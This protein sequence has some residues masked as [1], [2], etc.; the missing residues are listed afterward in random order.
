MKNESKVFNLDDLSSYVSY[1]KKNNTDIGFTNGCFDLLH[2]GH[3]FL[4]TEAKKHCDYLIVAINTDISVK[5]LKGSGRPK[6]NEETR[7]QKLSSRD[8]ID[9]I[10]LFNEETPIILIE[11][12]IPDKLFKGS[13]YSKKKV[14]GEDFINKNG[15]KLILIDTLEGYSTSD[16]INKS[17]N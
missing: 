9:A 12:L 6:D 8:E 2:K 1:L 5:I 13:D 15:G 4:L 14:V 16:I 7:I 3:L 17:G 10:I 11:R